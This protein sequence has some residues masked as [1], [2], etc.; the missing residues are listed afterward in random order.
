MIWHSRR[1]ILYIVKISYLY[2]SK[3]YVLI[4]V[5]ICLFLRAK[6]LAPCW[7]GSQVQLRGLGSLYGET[8]MQVASGCELQLFSYSISEQD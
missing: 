1:D 4:F 5:H 6:G 7:L 3:K 2:Y 8:F